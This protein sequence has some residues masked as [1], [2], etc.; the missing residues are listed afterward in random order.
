MSASQ[1]QSPEGL[2]RPASRSTVSISTMFDIGQTYADLI[3]RFLYTLFLAIDACFRL[4]CCLVLSEK[5]DPGLGTGWA[6][7]LK[8]NDMLAA[9]LSYKT[10]KLR[11][12]E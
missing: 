1:H 4:K 6:F 2:E 5:K 12:F 3:P 11:V 10:N 9:G 7:F 8:D